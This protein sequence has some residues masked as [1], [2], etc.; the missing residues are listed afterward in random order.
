M[1]PAAVVINV[2]HTMAAGACQ[3]VLATWEDD[4]HDSCS[5]SKRTYSAQF[6]WA[7]AD[8]WFEILH[9]GREPCSVGC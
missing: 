6:G 8:V 9:Y 2:M 3:R 5:V 7:C 4:A 1:H